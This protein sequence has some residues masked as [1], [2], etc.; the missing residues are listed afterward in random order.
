M[1]GKQ[2]DFNHWENGLDDLFREAADAQQPAP[3]THAWLEMSR[4]LDED[5]R[6]RRRPAGWWW[7]PLLLFLA[8]H[9]HLV[10]G[11][12][13]PIDQTGDAGMNR[14][15]QAVISLP[16][17]K[18]AP[19]DAGLSEEK[20]MVLQPAGPGSQSRHGN[21]PF[22]LKPEW[23]EET[24]IHSV[25]LEDRTLYPAR[26]R[27]LKPDWSVQPV[28]LPIPFP[29]P[30]QINQP[31]ADTSKIKKS[32]K[33]RFYLY[34]G[35]GAERAFVKS[36]PAEIRPAY[37]GGIGVHLTSK[38]SI[39]AGLWQTRKVYDATGKDYT[40][41]KGSYYDNPNYSI[42]EVEA[43]CAI[44]EIPIAVRYNFYQRNKHGWFG[45]LTVQNSLM[46]R[47]SYDYYYTRYGQPANGYYTYRTRQLEL[48]SGIGL[49][50]G[51]EHSIG[52][53]LHWQLAPYFSIPAAG[54]GEGSV[55]LSSTG[56]YTGLRYSFW[57]KK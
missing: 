5:E 50:V 6:K 18:I 53:R 57:K 51:Y 31:V 46:Q 30:A 11:Y 29:N 9:E 55:K 24:V 21:Q 32:S 3:P 43:D 34:G 33:F 10:Q 47:E 12:G 14:Y 37:G 35:A 4:L 13:T 7:L 56:I 23:L 54:I 45:Q 22:M 8:G 49:S 26:P 44:L 40:P 28:A 1:N 16:T 36:N 2:F 15:S 41:K 20:K 48:L 39:L 52:Q 42:R 25:A 17:P 19:R 38:W 27:K